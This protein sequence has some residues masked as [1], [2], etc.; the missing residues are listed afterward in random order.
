V[1]RVALAGHSILVVD[2]QP[3]IALDTCRDGVHLPKPMVLEERIGTVVRLL[4]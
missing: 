1:S 4:Q 3:L 2:D